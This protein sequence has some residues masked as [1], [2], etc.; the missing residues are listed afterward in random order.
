MSD[1]EFRSAPLQ[2]TAVVVVTTSTERISESMG[3]AFSKAFAA[4]GQAG[5]KPVGPAICKYTDWG[6]DSVI[7]EAGVPLAA[8]FVGG[9]EVVAG[10]IGGCVAAVGMHVGPYGKLVETYGR[11]QSWIEGLGREP[12]TILWEAYLNDPDTT[13]PAEL[14]TEIHW[15]V[16]EA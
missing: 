1:F 7:F 9:E 5:V 15:P 13:P 11:M 16:E 12:S 3:E 10:E 6:E 2:H 4:V 8:P 14:R